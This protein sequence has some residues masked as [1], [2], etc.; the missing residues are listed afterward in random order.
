MR[1]G[2]KPKSSREKLP[3]TVGIQQKLLDEADDRER[4]LMILM[5]STGMH[6][7]VLSQ[8]TYNLIWDENY[9]SWNRPKTYNKLRGAWSKAMRQGQTL[10][11][12]NKLR[13]RTPQRLWQI[14]DGLGDRCNV[15]G[16]CPLQLRHTHFVN[17]AR[18]GHNAFEIA[19]GAATDLKTVYSYYTIGMGE[20]KRLT[21]VEKEWLQWLM[22]T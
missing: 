9:Y 8:K 10:G 20:M 22:E 15:S 19:H 12:V 2:Y 1:K 16:L 13:G 18:L 11:I 21:D 4:A 7:R 6:P 3:L 17:R 14:I 5:L